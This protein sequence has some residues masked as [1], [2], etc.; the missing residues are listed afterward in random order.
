MREPAT[1]VRWHC[2]EHPGAH[3]PGRLAALGRA[4]GSTGAGW[5]GARDRRDAAR[6]GPGAGRSGDRKGHR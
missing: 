6:R 1:L 2:A 5:S 3:C 4:V